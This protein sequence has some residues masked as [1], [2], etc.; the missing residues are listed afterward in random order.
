MPTHIW[1]QINVNEVS[2]ADISHHHKFSGVCLYFYFLLCP[3]L[4]YLLYFVCRNLIL[5]SCL[6]QDLLGGHSLLL[7]NLKLMLPLPL[8]LQLHLDITHLRNSLRLIGARMRINQLFMVWYEPLNVFFYLLIEYHTTFHC[9][10]SLVNDL[11]LF[12][13]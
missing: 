6:W 4:I 5:Q 12:S 3:E 8:L 7:L 1:S 10:R 9:F 11:L 13:K 2:S